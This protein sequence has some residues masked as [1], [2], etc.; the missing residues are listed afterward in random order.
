MTVVQEVTLLSS[1]IG[2]YFRV[3]VAEGYAY[4]A[5]ERCVDRSDLITLIS[6]G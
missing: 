2:C 1:P 4:I 3:V 6:Y 5:D